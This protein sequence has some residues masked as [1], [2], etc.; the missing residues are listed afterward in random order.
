MAADRFGMVPILLIGDQRVTSE[1]VRTYAALAS[2]ANASRVAFPTRAQLAALSGQAPRTLTR[3]LGRLVELGYLEV[4]T[5]G[6][7]GRGARYKLCGLSTT[8]GAP[9]GQLSDEKG[10]HMTTERWP[11]DDKKVAKAKPL[12]SQNGRANRKNRINRG[13]TAAGAAPKGA[14]AAPLST[15][16]GTPITDDRGTFLPGTGWVRP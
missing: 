10:S 7:R 3:H 12:T 6:G 14:A 4:I 9:T 8:E 2:F 5:P 16:A 13:G 15:T 1:A 11:L